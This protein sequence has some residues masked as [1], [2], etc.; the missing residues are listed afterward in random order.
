[1]S[2][3]HGQHLEWHPATQKLAPGDKQLTRVDMEVAAKLIYVKA[4]YVFVHWSCCLF[5]SKINLSISYAYMHIFN[6]F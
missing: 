3:Y 2:D 4:Y 1:M 6:I 5:G